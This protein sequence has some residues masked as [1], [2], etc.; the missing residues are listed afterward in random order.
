MILLNGE[1]L[2]FEKYPNGEIRIDNEQIWRDININNE[3]TFKYED[4][5]DLIKLM[6][7]KNYIDEN[8]LGVDCDLKILY[9]PYS[10]MDRV[11]GYYETT[12]AFTLKYICNFI[13]SLNFNS[14]VVISPHSNVSMAL[15]NKSTAVYPTIELLGE[16]MNKI[17]F[18]KEKDILFYP[19]DGSAKAHKNIKGFKY[20]VGYKSR[21]FNTGKIDKLDIVGDI[22]LIKDAKVIILDDISSYAGT[23]II[24]AKKLKELGAKEVYLFVAHCEYSIFKGDLF[25]TDLIDK[26]FT[27]NSILDK[28]KI[29]I[30]KMHI[31][32][33]IEL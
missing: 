7:L 8:N 21:D 3:I 10:R 19:D 33:I 16:V 20:L 1:R 12:S 25:Q 31:F 26:V 30:E 32:D 29:S 18:D 23:F 15:L 24:S 4:E 14:V 2:N 6:F 11:E 17:G 9:L 22:N 5:S 13:N 27:T 28:E